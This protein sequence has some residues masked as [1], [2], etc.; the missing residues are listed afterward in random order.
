MSKRRALKRSEVPEYLLEEYGFSRTAATLAKL[1]VTGGGPRFRKIG[2]RTVV[3]DVADIDAWAA[4]ITS[5]PVASTSE[6]TAA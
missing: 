6:L 2:A 5:E 3:Y 4:S 1:A